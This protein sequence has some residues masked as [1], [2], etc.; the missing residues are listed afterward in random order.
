MSVLLRYSQSLKG[1]LEFTGN[2]QGLSTDP[3]YALSNFAQANVAP[4]GGNLTTNYLNAS[5]SSYLVMTSGATVK[6][7]ELVWSF[8]FIDGSPE[9]ST[10]NN[11]I[12][13]ITPNATHTIY[14]DPVTSQNSGP[15]DGKNFYTRSADVTELV[16]AAGAGLYTVG[17][18]P[19][20]LLLPIIGSG[21]NYSGWVLQVVYE[22]LSLP[23]REINT[24]VSNILQQNNASPTDTIMTGFGTPASGTVNGRLALF[25]GDGNICLDGESVYFGRDTSNLNQLSGPNN[26]ISNFF[27]SQ[28]NDGN[29]ESITVGDLNQTGTFGTH[30]QG[31]AGAPS[32]WRNTIDITNVSLGAGVI[33]NQT[34][35]VIRFSTT[36]DTF[37]VNAFGAQ[38]DSV[39]PIFHPTKSADK[40]IADVGETIT[41]TASFTNDGT[42]QAENLLFKGSIPNNTSFVSGSI[43][44]DG[45]SDASATIDNIAIGTVAISQTVVVTYQVAVD[46][47]PADDII[48]NSYEIDYSYI[49]VTAVTVNDSAVSNDL[50]IEVK[51]AELVSTKSVDKSYIDINETITYTTVINNIGNQTATNIIFNNVIPT[52][53]SLVPNSVTVNGVLQPGANPGT[54]VNIANIIADTSKTIV[55]K[56]TVGNTIPS[57][58]PMLNT[59]ITNYEYIVDPANSSVTATSTS[60]QISTTVNHAD[61]ISSGNFVKFSDKQFADLNSFVTYTITMNNTGNVP[62]NNVNLTDIVPVGSVYENGTLTINNL[63]NNGDLN[64]GINIGTV[65]ANSIT[66]VSFKVK[67]IAIPQQNPIENK[68][69]I[70]YTYTVN[71]AIPN[72]ITEAEDTNIVLTQINNSSITSQIEVDKQFVDLRDIVNYTVHLTNTG[73]VS[74]NNI[75]VTNPAPTGTNFVLNSVAINGI[76]QLGSNPNTGIVTGSIAAGATKTVSFKMQVGV[77]IPNPN[78][79]SNSATVNFSYLVDPSGTPVAGV[80]TSNVVVTQVNHAD[81]EGTE[82]LTKTCDK[83]FVDIGDLITYTIKIKNTGNTAATNVVVID[84]LNDGL[85]YKANSLIVDGTSKVE[86]PMSG[87]NIGNINPNQI[88]TVVFKALVNSIPEINPISNRATVN[89]DYTVNPSIPNSVSSSSNSNI[90]NTRVNHADLISEGNA[91]KSVDKLFAKVGEELNYT[92]NLKNT[93]NT[94]AKNV[95]ITD[96]IPP[97]TEFVLG[98]LM[99]DGAVK[100][101]ANPV[102]GI[103]IGNILSSKSSIINF[104]VLIKS[105]PT[106]KMLTNKANLEYSYIVNPANPNGVSVNSSTNVVTTRVTQPDFIG[107]NSNNFVKSVDKV[108][109]DVGDEATYTLYIKNTGNIEAENVVLTDLIQEGTAFKQGTVSIDDNKKPAVNPNLGIILDTIGVNQTVVVSFKVEVTSVPVSG[110]I[111]NQGSLY[112]NYTI[113]PSNPQGESDNVNSNKTNLNVAHGEIKT[114]DAVLTSNKINTTPKDIIT[115]SVSLKNTGN[116]EI[117]DVTVNDA[118]PEGTIFMPGT[119]KVNSTDKPNEN[120]TI[121]VHVGAIQPNTISIVSFNVRVSDTS[122]NTIINKASI[123]YNYFADPSKPSVNNI[124]GTNIVNVLNL[125]PN[126]DLVKTSNRDGAVVNDIIRYTVVAKNTG[127]VDINNIVL[128][129]IL[130]EEL[131]YVGNLIVNG[132][133]NTGNITLGVNVG[134]LSLDQRAIVSFDAKVLS[135]PNNKEI[136]NKTIANYN[137]I[138]NEDGAVFNESN[139]SNENS[140][141]IYSPSIIFEK[142]SNKSVVKQGDTFIYTILATN[143]GDIDVSNAVLKEILPEEFEVLEIKVDGTVISGDINTGISIGTITVGQTKIVTLVIKVLDL[144]GGNNVW[145]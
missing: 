70:T 132:V 80:S 90:V 25:V 71:P 124:I 63:L 120:P 9:E 98:S 94:D 106:N 89:Y 108:Y 2:T 86:E 144:I 1:A 102:F 50:E 61:L 145:L 62:A 3:C 130:Q 42:V 13:F 138:V 53:T 107:P 136:K 56:V 60:N 119:V 39:S 101:N 68:G 131:Q 19:S 109:V 45:T 43:T 23:I 21:Q 113:D 38:I 40:T 115:Y 35:G 11:A 83:Q 59:S 137:Y 100:P 129:D 26:P 116:T 72:E 114:N 64:S 91:V 118:I 5:S 78:P 54:G 67:I 96:I 76:A 142:S 117:I 31:Q 69:S 135:V 66:T 29:S 49:P 143:K 134:C 85:T 87:V 7:A 47:I 95:L 92:I 24:W 18:I 140:V 77:N 125:R 12:Q 37:I 14:P 74:A 88:K 33:N 17:K 99:V 4:P 34:S 20:T 30:N 32:P 111:E 28:I 139:E 133:I 48:K 122:P 112:F 27:K 128:T 127:P 93:G 10:K 73:N 52:G 65:N 51:H 110:H 121:G 79:I 58:N 84:S 126:L 6:Y 97:R 123:H 41:Y 105:L 16:K 55:F 141:A 75:I 82:N 104:K 15:F 81:L 103:N 57:I 22:D 36:G 46:D 44:V 8:N